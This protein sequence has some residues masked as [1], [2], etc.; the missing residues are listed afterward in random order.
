MS[1]NH[2]NQPKQTPTKPPVIAPPKELVDQ[3]RLSVLNEVNAQ[4]MAVVFM[5]SAFVIVIYFNRT[6]ITVLD[7]SK[8]FVFI[9]LLGFSVAY[10][11]RSELRLSLM[12]GFFYSGF[13]I[14]PLGLALTLF[15]NAQCSDTYTETYDVKK[16]ENEGSGFTYT[17]KDDAYDAFWHIRNMSYDE[18]NN[19]YGRLQFT[20]CDGLLG[21][22]VMQ[23]RELVK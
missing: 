4:V 19:R 6:L 10:F 2:L 17:L 21:M 3:F 20:F 12:D 13:G 9:G 22:K 15:I 23:R 11:V 14:A 16:R 8:L 1:P 7:A 5:A 18:V